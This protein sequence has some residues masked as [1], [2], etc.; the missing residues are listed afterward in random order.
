MKAEVEDV[1]RTAERPMREHP[2][3]LDEVRLRSERG[4]EHENGYKD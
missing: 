4:E 2:Q 3:F 1:N